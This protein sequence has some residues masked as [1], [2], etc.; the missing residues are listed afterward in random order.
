MDVGLTS[1][2]RKLFGN[3]VSN[4]PRAVIREVVRGGGA[5]TG[6]ESVVIRI[7]ARLRGGGSSVGSSLR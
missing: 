3:E 1:G 5:G 6:S 2:D 4:P 7:L